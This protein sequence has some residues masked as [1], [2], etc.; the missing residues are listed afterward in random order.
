MV[1]K[2]HHYF[3]VKVWR[4]KLLLYFANGF[5]SVIDNNK[6]Y[7]HSRSEP[8][9]IIILLKVCFVMKFV[10]CLFY[11]NDTCKNADHAKRK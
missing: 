7:P 2:C 5:R 8:V 4:Y 3:L 10:L 11:G 1:A 9:G 6:D